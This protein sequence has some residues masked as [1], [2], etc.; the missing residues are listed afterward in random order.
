MG[1]MSVVEVAPIAW[2]P[3]CD[4]PDD[5][6]DGRDMLLWL[7]YPAIASWCDGWRDTVGN[8]LQ[9]ALWA[10]VEGPGQ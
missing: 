5:R 2:R 4:I 3:I 1:V 8:E 9:G 7:G 10:D 6:K